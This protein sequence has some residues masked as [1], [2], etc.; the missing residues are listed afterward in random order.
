MP[1]LSRKTLIIAHRGAS[2]RAPENSLAAFTMAKKLGADAVE[3]DA[4]LS[5]DGQVVVIHDQSVDRTTNGKGLVRN[6]SLKELQTLDA[7]GWFHPQF[8]TERIPGLGEVF[9]AIG[10][11]MLINIELTNYATPKDDLLEKVAI[12]VKAHKLE[13]MV[14]FSSFLPCNI[15]RIQ[16]LLPKIPAGLLASPGFLGAFSRSW[17]GGLYSPDL[18]H[19]YF[20]DAS[21][22][23]VN[24]QHALGR[25]VNVWTVNSPDDI[26]KM[27]AFGVDG[28][29]TDDVET[30]RK[31]RDRELHGSSA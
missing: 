22:R 10:G 20:A 14:I 31:I 28:I 9:E 3:L 18:V 7:G 2:R 16:K 5:A 30:T 23:F 19:P 12:L 6:L 24:R 26:K 1:P 29:I 27:I 15:Q 4:K 21:E 25:G 8:K 17:I 11:K 13:G